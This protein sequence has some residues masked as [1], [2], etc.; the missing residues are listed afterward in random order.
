M[1]ENWESILN[2]D[3]GMLITKEEREGEVEGYRDGKDEIFDK[4][5]LKM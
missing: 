1:G 4:G 2:R 5:T 3:G